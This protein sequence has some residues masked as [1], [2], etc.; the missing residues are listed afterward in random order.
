MTT[1]YTGPTR[2]NHVAMSMAPER[3]DE[4]DLR[5]IDYGRYSRRELERKTR[6]E[7]YLQPR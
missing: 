2:F 3:L 5:T 6:L 4:S 1:D 7:H